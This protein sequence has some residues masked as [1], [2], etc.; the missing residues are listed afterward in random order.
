MKESI[1]GEYIKL[2]EHE[3]LLNRLKSDLKARSTLKLTT[4]LAT[5]DKQWQARLEDAK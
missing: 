4:H 1:S 5:L 3:C 2:S